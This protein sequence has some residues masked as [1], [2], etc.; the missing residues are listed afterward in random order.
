MDEQDRARVA[1]PGEPGPALGSPA[2]QALVP[3]GGPATPETPLA[4][5]AVRGGLWVIGSSYWT[6][7][8]GFAATLILTRLLPPEAFG[9]FALALFF[10]QLLRVQPKLGLGYAFAAH[11]E[12]DGKAIGTFFVADIAG[13]IAGLVLTLLAVPV[14]AYAG[15]PAGVVQTCVLLAFAAMA[16]SIMTTGGTFLE[17]ELRFAPTS[18]I[19]SVVFP[20]SYLPAF[21][22]ALQG[23]GVW[24]LVAQNLVYNL[25]FVGGVWWMVRR[26]LPQLWQFRWQ[27]DGS[28]ARQFVRFGATVGLMLLAGLLLT[29]LDNFMIGTFVGITVLGFYDRAYRTA[30]WP[31][32]LLSG[33]ISRAAFFTYARLQ[34]DLA[35]LQKTVTMMLWVITTLALPIALVIFI[36]APD[37]IRLLYG[38]RWL[39]STL[40]LRILVVYA[41]MRPLWENAGSLF[42]A[43]G[44]PLLTTRFTV[45]QALVLAI[46]GLPLT[47]LWGALGTCAAVGM[48]FVTGLV[49]TYRQLAREIPIHLVRAVGLPAAIAVLVVLGYWILNPL[50]GLNDFPLFVRVAV[51]SAY[52]LAGFFGMMILTQPRTTIEHVTYIWRLARSA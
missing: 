12:I 5:R 28:L 21:W 45:I 18:L 11:K 31:S 27:F 33:L 14:L 6:I 47:I 50:V 46:A 10:V 25:L 38:D 17:K 29:Q 35:R 22:L 44:K 7:G 1:A 30:Q 23:R 24:A 37:L 9:E 42:I 48:A 41:V 2:E 8:F 26:Q 4:Y 13:A 15:Y 49:L 52:A 19:Q 16:E 40:F 34:D 43:I 39:P 51:K 36:T 20:L 32:T 3:P